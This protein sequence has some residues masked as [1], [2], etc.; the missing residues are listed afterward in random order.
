MEGFCQ[1]RVAI[2]MNS[3]WTT[4][5]VKVVALKRLPK[6]DLALELGEMFY[7]L[8]AALDAVVYQ[9]AILA[10]GYTGQL[11]ADGGMERLKATVQVVQRN[12]LHTSVVLP[13]RWVVERSF[14]WLEKCRRLWKNCE[15]KLNTSLQFL[16]LAFRLFRL[17]RS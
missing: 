13:K 9:A 5:I 3:D 8:R 6:N 10:G 11:F 1:S 14:A 12:E 4:G 2:E 16:H 15:R 7:Q 17:R